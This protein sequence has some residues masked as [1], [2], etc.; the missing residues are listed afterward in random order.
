M[1]NT[2]SMEYCNNYNK[3]KIVHWKVS[4]SQVRIIPVLI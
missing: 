3:N 4:A 1:G 2:V